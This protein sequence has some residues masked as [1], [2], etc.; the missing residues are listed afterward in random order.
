MTGIFFNSS[1]VK[2]GGTD[3]VGVLERVLRK[4]YEPKTAEI[5]RYCIMRSSPKIILV[6][7]SRIIR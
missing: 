2:W 7:R 3:T 4:I 5:I 1:P 6:I